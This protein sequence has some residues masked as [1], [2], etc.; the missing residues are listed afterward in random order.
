MFSDFNCSCKSFVFLK[1]LQSDFEFRTI[2]ET[3]PIS[4]HLENL[5]LKWFSPHFIGALCSKS[6][7]DLL[8]QL[9]ISPLKYSF[10]LQFRVSSTVRFPTLQLRE[11]KSLCYYITMTHPWVL[12]TYPL[13]PW[14]GNDLSWLYS[15]NGGE[16]RIWN[17]IIKNSYWK[18]QIL[19]CEV[20][21]MLTLWVNRPGSFGCTA[22]TFLIQGQGID[23]DLAPKSAS[24]TERA[25]NLLPKYSSIRQI[26]SRSCSNS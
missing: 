10:L 25:A 14:L 1:I 19:P 16:A 8:P 23:W 15:D 4:S 20:K 13:V 17:E 22:Q 21:L 11:D 24:Q 7:Y 26:R 5:H 9:K 2:K 6:G 3:F 12:S 18:K